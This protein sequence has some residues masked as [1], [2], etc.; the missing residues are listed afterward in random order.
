MKIAGEG[1]GVNQAVAMSRL[2][3]SV[4]MVGKVGS[5]KFFLEGGNLIDSLKDSG[6]DIKGMVVD[7][8]YSFFI[9]TNR[10]K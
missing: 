9:C 5:D 10:N 8:F 3:S 6:V 1:K 4:C 7:E 2:G